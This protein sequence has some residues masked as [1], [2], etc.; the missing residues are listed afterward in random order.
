MTYKEI[1]AMLES[2]RLPC[3][4]HHWEPG[5][6]PPLPYLVFW[7]DGRND[8]AADNI[9][10]LKVVSVTLELYSSRKDFQA[11][12]QVERVLEANEIV[13]DKYEEYI[14]SE[15]LLEQ[16]YEFEILLEEDTDEQ[17]SEC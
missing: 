15:K 14:K 5:H 13:Y 6:V 1:Y 11:E 4:Y 8:F 10:Y 16:I 17:E 7:Y 3:T 12:Q 2:M 9:P